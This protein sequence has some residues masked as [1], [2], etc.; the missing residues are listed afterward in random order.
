MIVR[1][2][3]KLL[4][5]STILCCMSVPAVASAQTKSAPKKAQ[6][7]SSTVHTSSSRTTYS[8][9]VV[10]PGDTLWSI[11][12]RYHTTV[13]KLMSLNHLRSSSMLHIG[14]KLKVPRAAGLSG[15]STGITGLVDQ[16][17]GGRIAA[18]AQNFLGA[19]YAWGG[20][21]PSGFDCS[22]FVKYVYA[23]FGISL[24][25]SSYEMF[26]EGRAVSRG[27]LEPGMLVFFSTYGPG[28]SHVGIYIGGGR[29]IGAQGGR[30]RIDSLD[31]SYYW[32]SRYI[33]ARDVL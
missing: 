23:H 16:V 1:R 14:Q 29:F 33:G 24:P 17:L 5:S 2:I 4:V 27:D 21:S 32:A 28:A 26:Q 8:T 22:G 7:H 15:R 30:V 13:S 9:Y 18:Y 11:A 19:P 3:A 31:D 20:E 25:H 12:R 10:K 6:S